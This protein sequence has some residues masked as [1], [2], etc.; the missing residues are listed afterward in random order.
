MKRL[1]VAGGIQHLSVVGDVGFSC[2]SAAELAAAWMLLGAF[3]HAAH[4]WLESS[5]A[6]WEGFSLCG[7][8]CA[9]RCPVL[10][11]RSR[12]L[13]MAWKLLPL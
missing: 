4:L 12:F 8:L 10:E 1:E 11:D 6:S 13:F 5:Q 2:V 9:T 3:P 7:V